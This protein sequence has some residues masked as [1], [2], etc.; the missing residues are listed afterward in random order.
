MEMALRNEE[1]YR[2][3]AKN[4]VGGGSQRIACSAIL[5]REDLWRIAIKDGVPV[6]NQYPSEVP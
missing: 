6:S 3:D 2:H 5:R 1:T 4:P